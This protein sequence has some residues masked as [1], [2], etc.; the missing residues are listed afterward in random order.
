MSLIAATIPLPIRS[1]GRGTSTLQLPPD[2]NNAYRQTTGRNRTASGGY[3]RRWRH[4]V[5]G[6]KTG[7][8]LLGSRG[9]LAS[10]PEPQ[11]H[12]KES[13]VGYSIDINYP[14]DW[15]ERTASLRTGYKTVLQAGMCFHFQSGVWLE[16]FGAAISEPF[17]VT[18][19]LS[20]VAR[21]L[22]VID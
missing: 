6:R 14:P 22:I 15:D 1:Y 2:A 12:N 9:C 18:K 19:H 16:D 10:R 17:V 7:S 5:G 11:R 20:N 4:R 13:R 21:E 3:R 8:H